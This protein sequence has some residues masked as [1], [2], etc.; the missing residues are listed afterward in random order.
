MTGHTIRAKGQEMVRGEYLIKLQV[1]IAACVLIERRDKPALMAILTY[2]VLV[3][4]QR[5]SGRVVVK[6]DLLPIGGVMASGAL[7]TIGTIMRVIRS[8]TGGTILWRAFEDPVNMTA[9]ASYRCMLTV[10]MESKL[11]M[12]YIGRFPTFR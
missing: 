5:E 8:M 6:C 2:I 10:K 9:L 4:L 7:R 1:T 3:C 12:I 11:G